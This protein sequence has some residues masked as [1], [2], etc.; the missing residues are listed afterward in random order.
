MIAD[1]PYKNLLVYHGVLAP[2][3]KW[4]SRVVAYGRPVAQTQDDTHPDRLVPTEQRAI[5]W[6]ELMRR[7]FDLDVLACPRCSG[8][9]KLIACTTKPAAIRA[10][11][12]HLGLPTEAPQPHPARAPP[13]AQ[14]V[15]PFHAA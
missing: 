11:L 13:W 9:L 5:K 3:A 4:R 6:A 8:R 10:I 2:R 1:R 7:A 14:P 15:D 12:Q